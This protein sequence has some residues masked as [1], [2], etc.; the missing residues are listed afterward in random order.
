MTALAELPN[1]FRSSL[2]PVLSSLSADEATP[3]SDRALLLATGTQM[4]A[5]VIES[6]R[7]SVGGILR[8][9][10]EGRLVASFFRTLLTIADDAHNKCRKARAD[11]ATLDAPDDLLESVA[12]SMS[13]IDD[14]RQHFQ[15]T[16]ARL[17]DAMNQP[18]T[19]PP[20]W[21][22]GSER[23]ITFDEAVQEL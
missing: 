5:G 14:A 12:E 8:H 15:A 22:R 16:I 1:T 23:L 13:R 10:G 17:E 6:V 21:S 4:V 20:G 19:I 11:L 2:R 18:P 9:C 3:P 7:K